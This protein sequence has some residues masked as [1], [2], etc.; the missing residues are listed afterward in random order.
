MFTELTPNS[1]PVRGTC[2]SAMADL[3]AAKTVVVKEG[4][5]VLIPLGLSLN[6]PTLERMYSENLLPAS[7][8]GTFR[9]F[10]TEF[11]LKL[12]IRSSLAVNGLV[13]PN[14]EGVI[15]LDFPKEIQLLVHFPVQYRTPWAR[16][17]DLLRGRATRTKITIPAG[18][19]VAQCTLARHYTNYIA[20]SSEVRSGGFGSTG[21]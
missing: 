13:I 20:A 4:E 12:C 2:Y 10:L 16:F 5:T 15:D 21:Q 14:G 8:D 17:K 6:L 19:R 9:T 18:N 7:S 3:C 11:Y 1:Y